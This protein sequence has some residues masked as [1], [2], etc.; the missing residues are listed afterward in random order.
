LR[1]C[2]HADTGVVLAAL[3]D[4]GKVTPGFQRKCGAWLRQHAFAPASFV[5]FEDDHAKVSQKAL[6]DRLGENSALRLWA[7][8]VGA[9]HGRLKG[10]RLPPLGDGGDAWAAE[11]QRLIDELLREFGPLPD[12]P[13]V[14]QSPSDNAALWFNA[15][16]VA[17]ADWL[18][19]DEHTFPPSGPLSSEE[20]PARAA[21]QI[22]GIGLRPLPCPAGRT[23]H[24]L[25]GFEARRLQTALADSATAPGLYIV[26]GPMGCGKTEAALAAAYNLLSTGQATGL[27][28]ALPT[29]ITSNRIHR[30]VGEFL[31]RLSPDAAP[32]LIH[33]NS[34]LLDTGRKPPVNPAVADPKDG[35]LRESA[36]R[37]RDWFASPRRALLAPAGV[38]TVD[39]AL[40]G[41]VAAKHFFVRQYALAGKVVILDEV[42]SY[43]LYTGTL[44]DVLIRRLRELGA[45]VIVL[46]ATLTAARRRD[47]LAVADSATLS[48]AYPL[49][50]ASVGD[51]GGD[52]AA[53]HVHET[54]IDPGPSKTVQVCLVQ[55]ESLPDACLERA[56]HGECVLWIRNTVDE[57]QETYRRLS[58]GKCAGGP[59]IG[60]LHSRFPQFRREQEEDRWIEA[61]GKERARRPTNGCVLVSTQ[62]AEQSVDIDADLL[63]T[64][65]APTDML[66]QRIGRLWRH[67]RQ[68]PRGA[69]RQV[70]IA[71]PPLDECG[72]RNSSASELKKAFGKSAK[73]YAPY[74]LV[75]TLAEWRPRASLLLPADMR[76]LLEATYRD[77]PDEPDAW[78][79]LRNDLKRVREKLRRAAEQATA[80]WSNPALSDREDVQTRWNGM[81]TAMLLA[82][83]RRWELPGADAHRAV[84]LTLLDGT[85]CEARTGGWDFTTAKAIHRNL[86]RIP[87]WPV[88]AR[89][90]QDLSWLREYVPGACAACRLT[91]DHLRFLDGGDESCLRYTDE[92]GVFI[93]RD[94]PAADTAWQAH[95]G[96]D[97]EF[98]E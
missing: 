8:I 51:S 75:R 68:R 26:E 44:I 87:L 61:L 94:S 73:V 95:E 67:E 65:L 91:D 35:E 40:L 17:V 63:I 43:D 37:A 5:G 7:A 81:P 92:L 71:A 49:L 21:R 70:W 55:P 90:R 78:Q 82:V 24:D 23:F 27:Y 4:V 9:H 25:F 83:R 60:L 53:P 45:T 11:R 2:L 66:L 47:L 96:D 85:S 54:P 19:S 30:R 42:H 39:Q 36:A 32:R 52:P 84:G 12:E 64:D 22:E 28:F 69:E 46:S 31:R 89:L 29:Q 88:R 50:S 62:V 18:A 33:G 98:D 80:V 77:V 58:A 1:Q 76:P 74:V 15:G 13:P 20:I 16:L 14:G 72:L 86:I 97:D 48:N 38:G 57:A 56:R 41:V 79:E 6:Q 10:D 93:E 3:H 59:E 34:W